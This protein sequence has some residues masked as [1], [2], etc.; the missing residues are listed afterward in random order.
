MPDLDF[1]YNKEKLQFLLPLFSFIMLI[2]FN[3]REKE[4]NLQSLITD[5]IEASMRAS[6]IVDGT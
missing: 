2:N 1:N 3:E 4:R 6:A 5:C